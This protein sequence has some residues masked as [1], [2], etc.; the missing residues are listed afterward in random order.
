M[1]PNIRLYLYAT[2]ALL[3]ALAL[4]YVHH[5]KGNIT[6]LTAQVQ[7]LTEQKTE[8]IRRVD[9]ANQSLEDLKI[10][11]EILEKQRLEA[12]VKADEAR[13]KAES[14]L[15]IL[16]RQKPPVECKAAID[17]SIQQKDDLKW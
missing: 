14:Q 16:R 8:L 13:K 12:I 5:L 9:Q 2:G 7:V 11:G 10:S 4:F 6:D 1:W 3:V 17:W 15:V